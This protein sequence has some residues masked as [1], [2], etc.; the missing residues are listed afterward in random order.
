MINIIIARCFVLK[1]F[2]T[3]EQVVKSLLLSSIREIIHF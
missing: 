1:W 2:P 3:V